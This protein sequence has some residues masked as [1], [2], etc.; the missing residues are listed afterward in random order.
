MNQ[1]WRNGMTT[2]QELIFSSILNKAVMDCLANAHTNVDDQPLKLFNSPM[3]FAIKREI[4]TTG[5]KLWDRQYVDGNGGNISVRLSHQYI[6]CTP[7]LC[8]K[9]DLCIED[10][11]L[12]DLDNNRVCGSRP[13]TSEIRLHLEI[14]KTVP[15]AKAVIHCHPPYATAHAIAG[16]IPQGNLVPEQEVFVGQVALAPYETPGTPEFARTVVPFAKQHNTI[17]LSNHGIVCWADTVT[18]AEWFVEVME[19]YCRTIMIASQLRSPLSE[20]PRGKI[21]ELLKIKASLGLPDA[22]L[23]DYRDDDW[24]EIEIT[25][26]ATRDKTADRKDYKPVLSNFQ[27]EIEELIASTTAQII[28]ITTRSGQEG[29]F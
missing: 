19:T 12:V 21:E 3:A 15:K 23:P 17:L 4:V 14:Y 8:S 11:S 22:R 13:Q 9:G 24:D 27:K 7:T 2:S 5:K 6:L 1:N 29:P 28:A 16:V 10:L 18:H 20:L 25:S 26:I